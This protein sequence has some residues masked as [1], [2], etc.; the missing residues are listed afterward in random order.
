MT[1][2][3]AIETGFRLALETNAELLGRVPIFE[4]L[5]LEQL[6]AIA[7]IGKKTYFAEGVAIIKAGDKGD[8]AY[9]ILTG[10]ATTEPDPESGLE[11]EM[12]EPGMLVGELA[13]LVESTYNLTVRAK[14][15]VRALAMQRA[16]L[17]ELMETEPAIAHH[18]SLKLAGRLAAL[19]TDLRRL[20]A[21]FA[22]VEVS[23]D[24]SLAAAAG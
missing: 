24:E 18:F 23:L 7:N 10:L 1:D 6:A 9:L 17:Y 14:V 4:G 13:M 21:Q 12:V 2:D 15:R 16:D 11:A 3:E 8:T 5:S 20:D 22:R 19:A